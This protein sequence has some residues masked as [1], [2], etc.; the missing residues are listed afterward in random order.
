MQASIK[1]EVSEPREGSPTTGGKKESSRG[2]NILIA[3]ADHKR[4]P[5]SGSEAIPQWSSDRFRGAQPQWHDDIGLKRPNPTP[6]SI[7]TPL[8]LGRNTAPR[9]NPSFSSPLSTNHIVRGLSSASPKT[10]MGRKGIV[11]LQLAPSVGKL[12][13]WR[14]WRWNQLIG[15]HKFLRSPPS[16][17]TY[18]CSDVNFC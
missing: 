15:K 8:N 11:S 14:R 10:S 2:G 17:A 4:N 5:S 18:G 12:A 3:H 1:E 16:P 13:C 7:G 9:P 6:F